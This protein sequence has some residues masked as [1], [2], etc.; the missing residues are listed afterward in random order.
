MI[1]L[2]L[3]FFGWLIMKYLF[4]V[5]EK[6]EPTKQL[7]VTQRVLI[8]KIGDQYYAWK[9]IPKDEFITQSKYLEEVMNNLANILD[10]KKIEIKIK[11]L[12]YK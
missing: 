9:T 2:I 3:F 11:D 1:D 4:S 5:K 12:N 6:E 10:D 7:S 8:E